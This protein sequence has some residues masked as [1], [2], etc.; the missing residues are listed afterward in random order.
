ML[1]IKCPVCG[2]RPEIE[3]QYGGEA[4]RARPVDP[5]ALSDEAWAAFLFERSNPVG[6]HAERWRHVHGC[7]RFFNML[8]D[9]ESDRVLATYPAGAPRPTSPEASQK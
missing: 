8:R 3:F 6:M 4:H 1:L 7:G 9:T 2:D 5:D